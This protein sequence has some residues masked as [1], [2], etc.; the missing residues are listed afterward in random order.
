MYITCQRFGES[1]GHG[2]ACV[3]LT[4]PLQVLSKSETVEVRGRQVVVS[5]NSWPVVMAFSESNINW[6]LA[7]LWADTLND[8]AA[9]PRFVPPCALVKSVATTQGSSSGSEH[10][11]MHIQLQEHLTKLVAEQIGTPPSHSMW[12]PSRRAFRVKGHPTRATT[13]F[14]VRTKRFTSI[15]D[16][17]IE[18]ELETQYARLQTYLESGV[19]PP[20]LDSESDADD[21]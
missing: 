3:A 6:L 1:A 18:I 8:N 7:E 12:L 21:R 14:K 13:E 2:A 11:P 20:Q 10:K 16:P 9:T 5:T 15:E 17:C 19:V 4:Q